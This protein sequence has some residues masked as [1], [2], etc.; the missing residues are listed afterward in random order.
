MK[1]THKTEETKQ[2][3]LEHMRYL[4]NLTQ[5]GRRRRSDWHQLLQLFKKHGYKFYKYTTKYE[6]Q[7]KK[8]INLK[9]NV[10]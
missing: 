5:N 1:N 9:K 2:L 7:I 3:F 4:L 10:F 8:L 6:R